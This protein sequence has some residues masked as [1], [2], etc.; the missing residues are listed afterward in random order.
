M[1]VKKLIYKFI[2]NKLTKLLLTYKPQISIHKYK[3]II[4]DRLHNNL[5]YQELADK[6]GVC[7]TS[8]YNYINHFLE[9]NNKQINILDRFIGKQ[10]IIDS[11]C[12]L[13]ERKKD[14]KYYCGHHK[15]Y[16]VKVTVI[17]DIRGN[18]IYFSLGIP[19]ST[20]D[21]KA[22]KEILEYCNSIGVI[23][24]G[25]KGYIDK[26]L[27]VITPIKSYGEFKED[28]GIN[29]FVASIRFVI[30]RTFGW[31]KS[32][33]H[34]IKLLRVK[35]KNINKNIMTVFYLQFAIQGI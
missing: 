19:A 31:I 3:K 7:T 12:I 22:A 16:H 8:I 24:I 4:Y 5:T 17:T 25:D 32:R 6:Y 9:Y 21:I 28:S 20:H 29:E 18:I 11:T 15:A 34:I 27:K 14:K 33:F 2:S 13:I 30:E 35:V 10:V 26:I 23:V 1:R